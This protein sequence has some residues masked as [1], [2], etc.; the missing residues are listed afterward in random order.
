MRAGHSVL[1]ELYI[2]IWTSRQISE[3]KAAELRRHTAAV[4]KL[5][6]II[7]TCM[8]VTWN[9]RHQCWMAVFA[10]IITD[11]RLLAC[12]SLFKFNL[13][14]FIHWLCW[15]FHH[16]IYLVFCPLHAGN[17]PYHGTG[18]SVGIKSDFLP[19]DPLPHRTF[20]CRQYAFSSLSESSYFRLESS[21]FR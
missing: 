20:D 17:I 8:F 2:T 21:T 10:S 12:P 6:L 9:L 16:N 7:P 5:E 14:T 15:F 18:Y 4:L 1:I 13:A 3:I 11:I 19:S